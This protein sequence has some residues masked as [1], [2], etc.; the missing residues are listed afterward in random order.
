MDL[1]KEQIQKI[2][3]SIS[4]TDIKTYISNHI[5]EFNEY[6]ENENKGFQY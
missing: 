1:S 4:L 6:L 5:K 3:S 2:S